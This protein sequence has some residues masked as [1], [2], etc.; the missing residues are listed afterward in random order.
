MSFFTD[1]ARAVAVPGKR[2]FI[3]VV[4]AGDGRIRTIITPDVGAVP[5]DASPEVAKVYA[6]MA[7]PQ[8]VTGTPEEVEA[9]LDAKLGVVRQVLDEGES[10]LAALRQI[11]EQAKAQPAGKQEAAQQDDGDGDAGL[12][13]VGEADGCVADDQPAAPAGQSI[14]ESF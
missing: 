11:K 3:E 4:G 9:A 1:V 6:L 8:L 2:I 10:T 12:N 13:D 5:A 7:R 14:G